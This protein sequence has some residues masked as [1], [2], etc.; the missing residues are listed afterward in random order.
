ME[1]VHVLVG[2]NRQQDC[3][4]VDLFRQRHLHEDAIDVGTVI[5]AIDD[6]QQFPRC[7]RVGRCQLLAEDA[8]FF[9]RFHLVA[10]V[11]LGCG[12]VADQHY[13]ESG[14]PFQRGCARLPLLPNLIANMLPVEDLSHL[15]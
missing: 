2:A 8:Q 4:R 9:A 15:R 1:A 14:R 11:D 10:N 12:V 6:G 5:Q 13:R 7:D 3:A